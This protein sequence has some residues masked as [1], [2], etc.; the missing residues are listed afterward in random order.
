M[1]ASTAIAPPPPTSICRKTNELV[2]SM[3]LTFRKAVSMLNVA[4]VPSLPTLGLGSCVEECGGTQMDFFYAG[5]RGEERLKADGCSGIGRPVAQHP[6]T[7]PVAFQAA[8]D[9]PNC[10]MLAARGEGLAGALGQGENVLDVSHSNSG[11]ELVHAQPGLGTRAHAGTE[12]ELANVSL[13]PRSSALG[14]RA[15][16]RK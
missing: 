13:H 12:P 14:R 1:A 16:M 7:S 2:T 9:D 11:S 10:H 4:T 3:L 15:R 6:Q 5:T 8:T